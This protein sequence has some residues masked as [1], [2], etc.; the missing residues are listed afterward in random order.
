LEKQA[1]VVGRALMLDKCQAIY[2]H[3]PQRKMSGIN[4]RPTVSQRFQAAH[5]A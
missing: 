2:L 4:A 1:A 3:T 5:P